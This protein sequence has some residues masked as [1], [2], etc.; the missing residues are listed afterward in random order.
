M[1]SRKKLPLK[2]PYRARVEAFALKF[3]KRNSPSGSIGARTAYA[4]EEDS[5]GQRC[6]QPGDQHSTPSRCSRMRRAAAVTV[7]AAPRTTAVSPADQAA[8]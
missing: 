5:Q 7:A 2:T 4:E 3:R 6:G 1:V 8:T